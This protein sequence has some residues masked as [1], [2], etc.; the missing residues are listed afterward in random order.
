MPREAPRTILS[1]GVPYQR[2]IKAG[3][4][5]V[6]VVDNGSKRKLPAHTDARLP[7]SVK[8]VDSPDPRP[9]PAF[10][11]NWAARQLA[12]G[13]I[14]LLAID[15]ARIFSDGLYA[16]TLAAHDLVEDAFVYTLSWHL[17]PKV[18]KLSIP[19]GY[20]EAVEDRLIDGSGWPERPAALYDISVFAASSGRGFFKPV[21]ES[22]AFSV[23]RD[24]FVRLGGYDE[25]YTSPGGGLCN[26]EMFNRYV[27]RPGARNVCLL[28]EGTFHQVHGGVTT[29]GIQTRDELQAE[30]RRIFGRDLERP[31]CDALY[32]GPVRPEA[33]RFLRQSLDAR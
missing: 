8:L 6:I 19:E 15:G 5:E 16:A 13:D 22:N 12:R 31:M 4:Y 1:A 3:D 10:A 18:Q 20:D 26:L 11:L 2:G 30:H 14:L 32:L 21:R 9:S 28:S 7:A 27:M 17:G 29:S 23:R 25:R 33:A 24:L